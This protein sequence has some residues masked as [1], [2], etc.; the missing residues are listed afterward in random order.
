MHEHLCS[1]HFGTALHM[2]WGGGDGMRT[3]PT[4]RDYGRAKWAHTQ[5]YPARPGRG[6]FWSRVSSSFYH[7]CVTSA[8]LCRSAGQLEGHGFESC[9]DYGCVTSDKRPPLPEPQFPSLYRQM[10]RMRLG[11]WWGNVSPALGTGPGRWYMLQQWASLSLWSIQI[12]DLYHFLSLWK[13][14]CNISCKAVFFSFLLVV[15]MQQHLLS[16]S[17]ATMETGSEFSFQLQFTIVHS[18]CVALQLI[19]WN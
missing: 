16:S 12:S 4:W 9:L 6:P 3:T 2:S 15:R 14:S 1:R 10:N 18:L 11:R 7:S 5:T 8:E 17:H 19:F 13:T